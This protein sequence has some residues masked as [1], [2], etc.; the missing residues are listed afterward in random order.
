LK[1][2]NAKLPHGAMHSIQMHVS[3][4][5]LMAKGIPGFVRALS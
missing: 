2:E 4:S 5:G 1:E 3:V